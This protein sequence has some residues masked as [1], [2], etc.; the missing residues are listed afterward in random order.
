MFLGLLQ[1]NEERWHEED[2]K[3]GRRQHAA[4]H[5]DPNASARVRSGTDDRPGPFGS[6]FLAK[7]A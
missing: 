4:E 3:A 2:G 1:N 5:R 7:F 6:P